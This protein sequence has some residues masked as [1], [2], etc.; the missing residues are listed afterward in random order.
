MIKRTNCPITNDP[1]DVIFSR[2]YSIPEL[3]RFITFLPF[4]DEI[5]KLNFEIRFCK[6]SGLYFQT[7]VLNDSQLLSL[8]NPSEKSDRFLLDI[9]QQKLHSFAHATEEIL[10]L[11][12]LIKNRTPVVLD[13]GS[14]WGKWASMALAFGC[15]VYGLDIDFQAQHFCKSRGIKII[16]HNDLHLFKF[17]FINVDQVLEHLYNPREVAECLALCLNDGG[18]MKWSTPQHKSISKLLSCFQHN[19]SNLILEQDKLKCL[20]PL[21]HINLFSNQSLK[22]LART[23]GLNPV[24]LP[25][26]KWLG[27]S[28]L[29]NI[30]RQFNRNLITPWKRFRS[31]D[32]YLWVRK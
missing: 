21:V 3:N 26:L 14:S 20:E 24:R 31:Q 9:S 12:Q 19:S 28:Q 22:C 7:H 32:T 13:Y 11:R 25:Y 30:P 5:R 8:Y 10:V 6:T 2:P 15:D 29:W 1:S 4:S 27:A 16:N 17:D 23:V 18:Y